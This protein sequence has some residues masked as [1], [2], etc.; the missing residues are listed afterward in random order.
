MDEGQYIL[1]IRMKRKLN[2]IYKF[3]TEQTSET[4]GR[5]EW[6][7]LKFGRP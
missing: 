4:E 5:G 6:V 2:L 3:H 7:G 1:V